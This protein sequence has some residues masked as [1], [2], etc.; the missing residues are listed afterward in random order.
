MHREEIDETKQKHCYL[1]S[2]SAGRKAG[3]AHI[4]C[5]MPLTPPRDTVDLIESMAEMHNLNRGD[6]IITSVFYFGYI[7]PQ[8]PIESEVNKVSEQEQ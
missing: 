1:V 7:Y 8:N 5:E 2:W 6:I 3:H 4:Y